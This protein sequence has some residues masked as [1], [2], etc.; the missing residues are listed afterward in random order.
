MRKLISLL[1][2]II[3]ICLAFGGCN[4]N[5]TFKHG[6]N[7]TDEDIQFVRSLHKSKSLNHKDIP[8]TS[9]D[10]IVSRCEF[11]QSLYMLDFEAEKPYYICGYAKTN[12][13]NMLI[14]LFSN[15]LNV[16]LYTWYK[17]DNAN[18]IPDSIDGKDLCQAYR[19]LKC[20][21]KDISYGIEYNESFIYYEKTRSDG[22]GFTTNSILFFMGDN[23]R[24]S[25]SE[26]N[27]INGGVEYKRAFVVYT[28]TDGTKYIPILDELFIDGN[29]QKDL[30]KEE[31]GIYYDTFSSHLVRLEELDYESE[32]MKERYL[33][34]R[35]D[36]L[37]EFLIVGKDK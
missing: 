12:T 14:S 19:L 23:H 21:V 5:I 11:A 18:E 32:T 34:L 35:V 20:K 36:V 1:I 22:T 2:V 16:S 10:S 24:L 4:K 13:V 6:D 15:G 28:S 29:S 8:S 25:Q 33:G 37:S 9:F 3:T 30:A 31:L 26:Y 7:F 27:T 17:F